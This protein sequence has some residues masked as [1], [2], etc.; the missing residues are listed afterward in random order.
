[1]STLPLPLQAITEYRTWHNGNLYED[2][3]TAGLSTSD[4]TELLALTAGIHQAHNIGLEDVCQIHVF[5]NSTNVLCHCLDTSHHSGQPASLIICN[6]LI[7]W[8]HMNPDNS[9]FLHHVTNSME[10]ED[11][12][13][14]HLLATSTH[15][16]VG[17]APVITADYAHRGAVTCML[18]GWN[19]LFCSSKYIGSNFLPLYK[20]K[21][22]P[23][24]PTHVKS[25]LW[26]R[27]T[28]HSHSMT[29]RLVQCTTGHAPIGA[30][31]SWFFP[32][33]PTSCRCNFP[34]ETVSHIIYQCPAH[35]WES[36]PKQQLC[37]T[38]LVE[39]LQV[40]ETVFTFNVSW[41]HTGWGQYS[42]RAR[43]LGCTLSPLP[44]GIIDNAH[45]LYWSCVSPLAV[46]HGRGPTPQHSLAFT[47]LC[48]SG[49]WTVTLGASF[50]GSR[51]PAWQGFFSCQTPFFLYYTHSGTWFM[52]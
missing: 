10:L 26:M 40:N 46:H 16:E 5:S 7:P 19:S 20:A 43:T 51:F 6:M 47:G 34:M 18:D 11:H 32:L 45:G 22:V 15:V 3:H 38:W 49:L 13:L 4:N 9:L 2:W 17:G 44:P 27:K 39:F 25:G 37:Y 42:M 24:V 36:A 28:G 52:Y 41:T 12:Q 8:F 48:T 21:G 30:Y 23:L 35:T 31:R 29:A 33:E 50:A 14:A 1:M